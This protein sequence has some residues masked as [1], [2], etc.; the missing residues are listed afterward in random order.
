MECELEKKLDFILGDFF[1]TPTYVFHNFLFSF[2]N[3]LFLLFIHEVLSRR[4]PNMIELMQGCAQ[5]SSASRFCASYHYHSLIA[6][7]RLRTNHNSLFIPDLDLLD[8]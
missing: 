2:W 3:K 7:R 4:R 8:T 5:C 6:C 1:S